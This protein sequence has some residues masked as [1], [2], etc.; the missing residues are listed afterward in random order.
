M[1]ELLLVDDSPTEVLLLQRMLQRHGHAVHTAAD[2]ETALA[3]VRRQRPDLILMDVVLP[4]KSGFEATRELSADHATSTIPVIMLSNKN[5]QIDRIWGL[6][7]G[8]RAYLTKP[9]GERD[10]IAQIEQVL[11]PPVV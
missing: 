1:A 9:I 5:Q 10:L 2:A 7:Q 8:A 4:G 11:E 3:V 6:R